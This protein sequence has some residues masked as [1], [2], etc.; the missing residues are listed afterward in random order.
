M[1]SIAEITNA[2]NSIVSNDTGHYRAY[3]RH[4]AT[5]LKFISISKSNYE[6]LVM[7]YLYKD[8][9]IF[10]RTGYESVIEFKLENARQYQAKGLYYDI[11]LT[12]EEKLEYIMEYFT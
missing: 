3:H 11:V 6:E 8:F 2:L 1:K 10:I 9:V 4:A 5:G 12:T 7:V